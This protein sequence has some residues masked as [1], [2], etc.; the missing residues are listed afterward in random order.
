MTKLKFVRSYDEVSNIKTFVFEKGD[1]SWQPGQ[2]KAY[3]LLQLGDD[4]EKNEH[5]FT[6]ASEQSEGEIHI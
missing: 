2:Y 4:H 6:I 3:N 1:A 5:W